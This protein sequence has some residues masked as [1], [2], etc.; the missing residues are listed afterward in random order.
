MKEIKIILITLELASLLG[1]A[2]SVFLTDW[3]SRAED[4]IIAKVIIILLA[5][6]AVVY[7]REQGKIRWEDEKEETVK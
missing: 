1:V 2:I 7:Q 5:I 3:T 6:L 4:L